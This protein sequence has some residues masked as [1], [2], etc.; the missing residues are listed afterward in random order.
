[1]GSTEKQGVLPGP[2]ARPSIYSRMQVTPRLIIMIAVAV[3]A[4]G[5]GIALAGVPARPEDGA[6]VCPECACAWRLEEAGDDP[7]VALRQ[8]GRE[9]AAKVALVAG[10][11]ALA[12]GVAI[13]MMMR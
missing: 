11:A 12:A 7:D 5:L 3:V 1:M 8:R 4:A 6:I 9:R 2:G 13:Y 10:L